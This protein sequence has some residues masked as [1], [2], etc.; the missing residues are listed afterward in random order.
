M[1]VFFI[2]SIIKF[3]DCRK[4]KGKNKEGRQ[5]PHLFGVTLF[6]LVE[7]KDLFFTAFPYAG[8]NSESYE[9]LKNEGCRLILVAPVFSTLDDGDLQINIEKIARKNNFNLIP[10]IDTNRIINKSNQKLQFNEKHVRALLDAK[11]GQIVKRKI[12]VFEKKKLM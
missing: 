7:K 12:Y 1:L 10:M 3:G 2:I 5:K 6:Y 9:L 11:K 8:N 4:S